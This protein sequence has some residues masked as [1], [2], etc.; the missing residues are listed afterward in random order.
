MIRGTWI[1]SPPPTPVYLHIYLPSRQVFWAWKGITD[2]QIAETQV[3]S[4]PA[5]INCSSLSTKLKGNATTLQT[6]TGPEGSRRL[7]LRD[8]EI[9]GTWRWLRLLALHTG[10][11][12]PQEVFLVPIPV[13]DRVDPMTVVRQEGL[14]QWK[15]GMSPSGI[16]LSAR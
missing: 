4:S 16:E 15:I 6:W 14:C 10:R 12:Y 2:K 7:K 1:E 5:I 3:L 9:F 11:L 13:R 8:F